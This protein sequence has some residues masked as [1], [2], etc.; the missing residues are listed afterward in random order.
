MRSFLRIW[1]HLLKKS[2]IEN[3]IFYVVLIIPLDEL[4]YTNFFP[5]IGDNLIELFAFM[6]ANKS[7]TRKTQDI[8]I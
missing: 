7:A 1:S 5:K 6:I 4:P 2:L 3:F 8:D